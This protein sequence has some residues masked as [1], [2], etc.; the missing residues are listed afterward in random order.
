MKNL[1]LLIVCVVAAVTGF[2]TNTMEGVSAAM[3]IPLVDARNLF[4]KGIVDT[5]QERIKPTGFLSSF[6]PRVTSMTKSVSIEVQRGTEKI[7]VDVIR[8]T[9][10][11]RNTFSKSSEKLY[12]PPLYHEY[13]TVSELEI[14]DKAMFEQSPA[15]FA[16]MI[17]KAADYMEEQ[18][19][20][21]ERAIELQ[22]AQGLQTGI[23]VLSNGDNIDFRRKAASMVDINVGGD[24][25]T[26]ANG[27]PIKDFIDGATFLRT[28]GKSTSQV[29]NAVVGAK[30][31][32][33]LLNNENFSKRADI[34]SFKLDEVRLD[35]RNSEGASPAGEVSAGA[36]TIRLWTYPGFYED[37]SG[38]MVPFVDESNVILIPETF[39]G[40]TAFAAVPQVMNGEGVRPQQGEYLIQDFI[41][42]RAAT[43]EAHIKSAPI[44]VPTSIDRIYT[45]KVTA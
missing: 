23:I 10:G 5:L 28:V 37:A 36:W 16:N 14:Y 22:A 19:N 41:D 7:A 31:L 9:V 34:R 4:T 12:V 44:A 8:G 18:K 26:T 17:Q 24:Y 45:M 27:D 39:K 32:N 6:F 3:A 11:N 13:F 33:A 21:I 1:L 38:T 29:V 2:A 43:H 15:A 20:K 40:C 30:A 42:E 25:W 35:L